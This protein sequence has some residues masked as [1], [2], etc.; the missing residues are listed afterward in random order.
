MFIYTTGRGVPQDDAEAVRWY[1]GDFLRAARALALHFP[2]VQRAESLA[3]FGW[4]QP[5]VID[6]RKVIVAGE[7]VLDVDTVAHGG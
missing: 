2:P 4:Q 1:G 5:I 7:P 3:A 6:P